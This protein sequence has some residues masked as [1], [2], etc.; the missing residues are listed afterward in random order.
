MSCFIASNTCFPMHLTPLT[1]N[2]SANEEL[3]KG[4]QAY[5]R[6]LFHFSMEE[7]SSVQAANAELRARV[8]QLA[9]ELAEARGGPGRQ[10]GGTHRRAEGPRPLGGLREALAAGLGLPSSPGSPLPGVAW[11]DAAASAGSG[12]KAPMLAAA[13]AAQEARNARVLELLQKKACHRTSW[14]QKC[15][16]RRALL[17]QRTLFE[18]LANKS[19]IIKC[20]AAGTW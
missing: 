13:D 12:E 1:R 17:S 11:P 15:S 10:G 2:E 14:S 8:Q 7:Y 16:T 20:K 4:A 6:L 18:P 9:G 5:L 3:R 19:P